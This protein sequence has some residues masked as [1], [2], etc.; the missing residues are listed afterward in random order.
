MKLECSLE[1]GPNSG[2]YRSFP[3]IRDMS[4]IC[5]IGTSSYPMYSQSLHVFYAM[6]SAFNSF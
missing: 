5:A 6:P 3:C 4:A 1:T 2:W